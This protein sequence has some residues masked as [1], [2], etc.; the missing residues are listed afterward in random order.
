MDVGLHIMIQSAV[1]WWTTLL[2]GQILPWRCAVV[3]ALRPCM[4][5]LAGSYVWGDLPLSVR[6]YV[7]SYRQRDVWRRE[8][9]ASGGPLGAPPVVATK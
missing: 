3:V 5:T 9:A 6:L 1:Q 7:H 8:V 2:D 4:A